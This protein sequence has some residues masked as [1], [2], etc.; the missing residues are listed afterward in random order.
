M[1]LQGRGPAVA[2]VSPDGEHNGGISQVNFGTLLSGGAYP[3]INHIKTGQGWLLVDNSGAP[4]PST[5][6]SN[7][8]PTAISNGGVFSIFFIPLAADRPGQWRL[9]WTG[10]GTVT[11]AGIGGAA[12]DGDYTGTPNEDP[13]SGANRVQVRITAGTNIT[14]IEFFHEDDEELLD[15]GEIFNPEFLAIMQEANWGVVRF[16]DWQPA[17]G[18]NVRYW[19]DRKP[20]T[21]YSYNASEFRASIYAGSTTNSGDDYSCSAPSG[22]GGLVDKAIVTVKFNASASGNSPTLNVNST[23]ATLIRK[24]FPESI[25]VNTRPTSGK[26]ATLVYDQQLDVWLK[27][28]GDVDLD[29]TFLLNG[30]P[31]EIML[32]LCVKI[33]AH[34][35]F[36][37]TY[38]T[39]DP[40]T[41]YYEELAIYVRDNKPSWMIPYYEVVPNET[42]NTG[43]G[44]YATHYAE[45]KGYDRWSLTPTSDE[46]EAIN[47]WV[48]MV[49]SVIGEMLDDVHSGNRSTYKAIMGLHTHGG[50]GVFPTLRFTSELWV[51]EGGGKTPAEDWVTGFACTAYFDAAYSSAN[52]NAQAALYAAAD[53]AGKLVIASDYVQTTTTDPGGQPGELTI[54]RLISTVA[55]ALVTWAAGHNATEPTIYEG[56]W[57][58]GGFSSNSG[59]V[60]DLDN[61]KEAARM[62]LE[63]EQITLDLYEDLIGLGFTTPSQYYLSGKGVWAMYRTTLHDTPSPAYNAIVAFNN[64]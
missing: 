53:A 44:F 1:L 57:S 35:W 31:P 59:P 38:L 29:H 46:T 2:P 6:N 62:A 19:A 20:T 64:P 39:C 32:A 24:A 25:G 47:N 28:G 50:T 49:G 4:A 48:G 15:D 30:V 18:S 21:Y 12:T 22:W 13:Q 5:L 63:M 61:L 40:I 55:P 56:G 36:C 8:Y 11:V 16:L 17:N 27:L 3:F 51:A 33:G 23:G 41:D 10:T 34:P 45:W 58:D 60:T 9:R 14:N 7:G 54:A 43:A 42:W 37:P 26:F 52:K